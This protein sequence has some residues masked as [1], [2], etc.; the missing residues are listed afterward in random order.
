MVTALKYAG[1]SCMAQADLELCHTCTLSYNSLTLFIAVLGRKVCRMW[2]SCHTRE[3]PSVT[4]TCAA[5]FDYTIPQVWQPPYSPHFTH[6]SIFLFKNQIP[7]ER[8]K[9]SR[10]Q[11]N[12]REYNDTAAHY[13]KKEY[14]YQSR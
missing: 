10:H 2:S 7:L 4:K 9:V 6:S 11:G 12:P 3:V 13:F 14:F 8:N 5:V 1:W